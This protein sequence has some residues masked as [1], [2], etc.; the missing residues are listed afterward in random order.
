[1]EFKSIKVKKQ[2]FYITLNLKNTIA[3]RCIAMKEQNQK[4]E[5]KETISLGGNIELN[6]FQNIEKAK[7][8]VLK[9][10]IGNYAKQMQ[11]NKSDYKK[12]V[13]TLEGNESNAKIRSEL[14]AGN[15]SIRGNDTQNNIFVAIDGSLK[16]ILEQ[17]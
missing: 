3:M 5:S 14:I 16:K 7:L 11:E 4:S 17:I 15:N 12:L 8:V 13:I 10:I 9:K 6:G 1:M 2:I